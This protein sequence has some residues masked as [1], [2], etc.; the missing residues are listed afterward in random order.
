MYN[1]SELPDPYGETGDTVITHD[2]KSNETTA[3][4][5]NFRDSCQRLA[6][7]NVQSQPTEQHQELHTAHSTHVEPKTPSKPAFTFYTSNE[8]IR[9]FERKKASVRKGKDR[10]NKDKKTSINHQPMT[11]DEYLA[12]IISRWNQ[13]PGHRSA[14]TDVFSGMIIPVSFLH[15]LLTIN[16]DGEKLE[17]L[18]I[19]R[20][21][22]G[23]VAKQEEA[24]QTLINSTP[25]APSSGHIVN[26]I[27]NITRDE[28]FPRLIVSGLR[29]K[30]SNGAWKNHDSKYLIVYTNLQPIPC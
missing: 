4:I 21:W 7:S 9:V 5:Q 3:S 19:A 10:D 15:P 11:I 14:E 18:Q 30:V 16:S 2:V 24:F 17:L 1:P 12:D 8:P 26:W 13:L 23:D 27:N 20:K 29:K 6:T 25:S 28:P 22:C